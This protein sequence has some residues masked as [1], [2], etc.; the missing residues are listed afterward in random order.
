MAERRH[1][2]EEYS[3]GNI[4][5]R[6]A[7][8]IWEHAPLS[9]NELIKLCEKALGWKRTTTYTV[10]KKLIKQKYSLDGIELFDSYVSLEEMEIVNERICSANGIFFENGEEPYY[11]YLIGDGTIGSLLYLEGD[12]LVPLFVVPVPEN[13]VRPLS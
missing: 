9:T 1:M 6:F 5:S 10:L 13:P 7:D 3:L 8:I 12:M 4:E 11:G 2:V